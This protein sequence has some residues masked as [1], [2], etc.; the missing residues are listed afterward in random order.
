MRTT[1][2][3]ASPSSRAPPSSTIGSCKARRSAS[4]RFLPYGI[5][6]GDKTTRSGSGCHTIS[7]RRRWARRAHRVQRD[8]RTNPRVPSRSAQA[9]GTDATARPEPDYGPDYFSYFSSRPRQ[10]DR[11]C[12]RAAACGAKKTAKGAEGKRAKAKR[13]RGAAARRERLAEKKRLAQRLTERTRDR[14][15]RSPQ[16]RDRARYFLPSLMGANALFYSSG[17]RAGSASSRNT[18][19]GDGI[20]PR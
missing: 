6:Y 17:S 19:A 15:G 16:S 5:A 13:E 3:S 12:A 4:W 14:T 8:E 18:D 11:S 7:E 10:Q 20:P 2:R 1:F 9:S